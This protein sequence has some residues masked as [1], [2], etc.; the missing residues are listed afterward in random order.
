MS[1]KH[2][3][4]SILD[5]LLLLKQRFSLGFILLTFERPL[6]KQGHVSEGALPK[7]LVSKPSPHVACFAVV[8]FHG[9]D[10]I[11]KNIF[12]CRQ[13]TSVRSLQ[14]SPC[15]HIHTQHTCIRVRRLCI[16]CSR[17]RTEQT[18]KAKQHADRPLNSRQYPCPFFGE[19]LL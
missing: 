18:Q 2:N 13:K 4:Y 14:L 1:G 10:K 9:T 16:K 15:T 12:E 3:T 17:T 11:C 6:L 5:F 8:T 19:P 7:H